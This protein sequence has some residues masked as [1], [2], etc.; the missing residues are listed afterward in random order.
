[1]RLSVLASFLTSCVLLFSQPSFAQWRVLKLDTQ[2][3]FRAVHAP[4]PNVCWIGGSSGTVL[5]TT[6]G[7]EVWDIMKVPGADSLDF[8]GIYG[9]DRETAVAMSA[10]PAEQGKARIY[11]TSDGGDSWEVVYQTSQ[12]GVFL[13]GV[14]FWNNKEGIC[15]GDPVG[16]RFFILT[17]DDGGRTWQELPMENRPAAQEKEAAFAA[18]NSSLITVGNKLAFI[19]TGGAD[20]ARVLRSDDN[21]RTWQA[22]ETTLPAGP[23]SGIFG[24]Q[25]WTNKHGIAVGGDYVDVKKKSANVLLTRDGGVSWQLSEGMVPAGLKEAVGLYHSQFVNYAGGQRPTRHKYRL[26]AVGAS[27]SGYSTDFGKTWE[28]LS[29]EPFHAVSFAGPTGFAVGGKGLIG[30]FDK[31]PK[32][33]RR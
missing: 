30:K 9:F 16:G 24:L 29:S 10:G 20:M 28:P 27:G 15:F 3:N 17:T 11:R 26:V 33:R 32:K 13:D 6:D 7:G 19:G 14:S 4:R 31:F 18:S 25:F 22:A 1:M 23:T 21:G 2:A 8:R 12:P 5:R